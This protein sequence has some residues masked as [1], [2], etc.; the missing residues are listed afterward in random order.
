M[1]A[2]TRKVT[3]EDFETK[4]V[5]SHA[6]NIKNIMD[7]EKLTR[8]F[9]EDLMMKGVKPEGLITAASCLVE[10]VIQLQEQKNEDKA[11]KAEIEKTRH[12]KMV[13][14]EE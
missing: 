14:T 5:Q 2:V 3:A 6:T 11:E 1:M 7:I 12:L 4:R 9:A 13:Q 8:E 10:K